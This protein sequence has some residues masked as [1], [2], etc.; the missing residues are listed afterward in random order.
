MGSRKSLA[1]L[2]PWYYRTAPVDAEDKILKPILDD[3]H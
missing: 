1:L 2:A 3:A